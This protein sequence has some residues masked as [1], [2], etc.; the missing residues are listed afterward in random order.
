M[1]AQM[2]SL[3]TQARALGA[4]LFLALAAPATAQK[5][6]G[7]W[8]QK[9]YGSGSW[10]LTSREKVAYYADA[11]YLWLNAEYLDLHPDHLDGTRSGNRES[12]LGKLVWKSSSTSPGF[13]ICASAG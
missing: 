4:C 11:K 1:G 5:E 12:R 2:I 7:E 9:T 8:I 6:A 3:P 10:I 13:P